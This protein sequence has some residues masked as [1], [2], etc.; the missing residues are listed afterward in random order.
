MTLRRMDLNDHYSV[1]A[2]NFES[3]PV[4]NA[5]VKSG[6]MSAHR[7][8][9]AELH[10]QILEAKVA[11][12]DEAGDDIK[13]LAKTIEKVAKTQH[14]TNTG[15]QRTDELKEFIRN[16]VKTRLEMQSQSYFST[17]VWKPGKLN[18]LRQRFPRGQHFT[19]PVFE[20]RGLSPLRLHIY[21]SGSQDSPEGKAAVFL[22]GPPHVPVK[23]KISLNSGHCL[24]FP[25]CR[26]IGS[27]RGFADFNLDPIP[28]ADDG[29][30]Q[31]R[32]ELV[33]VERL[34]VSAVNGGA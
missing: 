17:M 2:T 34:L 26:D 6:Q 20:L 3:C 21:P 16:E 29:Q 32:V 28:E 19:S 12:Q 23:A 30:V 31:I 1:C 4:C 22:H 8:E 15:R 11:E 10:V 24:E 33:E 7:A 25:V 27:G 9:K 5:K 13:D 14:V 18:I